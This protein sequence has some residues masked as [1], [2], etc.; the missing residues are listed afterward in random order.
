MSPLLLGGGCGSVAFAVGGESATL[1]PQ[2]VVP[3]MSLKSELRAGWTR[4]GMFSMTTH[5]KHVRA[6]IAATS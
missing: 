5:D 1:A 3:A 6:M 2:H 4:R